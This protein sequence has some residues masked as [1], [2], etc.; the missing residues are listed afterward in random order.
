MREIKKWVVGKPFII[1]FLAP[2][3]AITCIDIHEAFQNTKQ[4]RIFKHQFP[5]HWL[6]SDEAGQSDGA[7]VKTDGVSG[8]RGIRRRPGR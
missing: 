2:Q 7:F 5:Y 3:L 8:V 1:A 4:R 6:E